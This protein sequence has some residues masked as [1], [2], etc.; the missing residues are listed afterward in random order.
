MTTNLLSMDE[1]IAACA[2]NGI[3]WIGAWR[4]KLDQDVP[5][6]RRRIE[7]AGLKVS[8]LCRGGMF[9]AATES[10]R[11]QRIEE[12]F[13]A[14]D[15]AAELGTEVLVLVNGPAPDRHID[16]ARQ[17]VMDGIAAVAPYARQRRV[18]L[19]IEPLHPMFAGDRSVVV[20]LGQANT[21]AEKLNVPE[22]GV[23]IDV[24][25]VWWDPNVYAEIQR[26]AGRILGFHVSDWMVP[27]SSLLM[28]RGMMG[29]GVIE[30]RRLRAEVEAAGYTGPIEVEIFNQEIWNMPARRSLEW[31]KDAY[32][33]Y[34]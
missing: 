5:A 1:A 23:V 25:H 10:E 18:K 33:E 21:M 31:M 19:G 20:T 13:R 4:H 12:N 15:E 27:T 7:S 28:G 17:M 8:S 26:S 16:A 11:K 30:L 9:P 32:L 22:V 29:T 6:I 3:P 24:Y 34:C 2:A 14:V